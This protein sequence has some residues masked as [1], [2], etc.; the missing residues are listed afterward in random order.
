MERKIR[1]EIGKLERKIE[2][3]QEDLDKAV[4]DFKESA[5]TYDT[6]CIETFIPGKIEEITRCRMEIE[7]LAQQKQMLEYLLD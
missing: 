6:H 2:W 3:K 7:N 4:M 1:E 5:V